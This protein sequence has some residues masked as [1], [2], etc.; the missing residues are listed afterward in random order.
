MALQ[1][2]YSFILSSDDVKQ[3]IWTEILPVDTGEY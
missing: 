1:D 3:E 2:H